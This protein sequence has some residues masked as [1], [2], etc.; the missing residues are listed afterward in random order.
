MGSLDDLIRDL[1][2]FEGRKELVKELR[3]KIRKPIPDVRK[4]IRRRA[5]DTLPERG[6]LNVWVSK[7]RITAVIKLAGRAAGVKLKG[8]R[9]SEGGRSDVNRIDAGRVRAPSWGRKGAGQWHTQTVTAGFFTEPATEAV[10]WRNACVEA[11]DEA[12]E[13]IRRG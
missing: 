12:A 11:I 9:N 1:R 8:G 5:L 3:K 7:I 2:R 4:S 6:G 13:V 10:A